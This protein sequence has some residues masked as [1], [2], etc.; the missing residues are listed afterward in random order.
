MS[1]QAP[2]L[3]DYIKMISTTKEIPEFDEHFE[4]TYVPFIVNRFFS[5]FNGNAAVIANEANSFSSVPKKLH[6][7]FLHN[8]I[9]KGKRYSKWPKMEK[10]GKILFLMEVYNY[11]YR[12]AREICNLI[13]EKQMEELR[14][15]YNTKDEFIKN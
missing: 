15:I 5:L 3:F 12:K 14:K 7:M 10:D 11:N 8:L 2:Q 9:R 4:K 6:F 1:D 13:S